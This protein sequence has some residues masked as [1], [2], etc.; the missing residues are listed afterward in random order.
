MIREE[1]YQGLNVDWQVWKQTLLRTNYKVLHG[2]R[3]L[4][5][6][7]VGLSP[8]TSAT[9]IC[10]YHQVK[11]GTLQRLPTQVVR[12]AGTTSSHHGPYVQGYTRATMV[13]TACSELVIASESRK[14]DHSSDWSLQLDSMK[15]ES[16]V[17]AYQQ[18][19]GEYVPGPCTHRPSSHGS[20]VC[21]KAVL[22]RSC[23]GQN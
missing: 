20:W 2:C 4:V 8:A 23:L 7:G 12:K 17:I 19:C 18:R 11:L 5:P 14:A 16:L 1:P 13:G 22:A 10:S 15:L 9:P 6:W 3:Q 21:L